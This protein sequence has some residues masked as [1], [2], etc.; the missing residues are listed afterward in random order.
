M[1]KKFLILC[2]G[3]SL[4]V[5]NALAVPANP[6]PVN[7]TQPDGS[8]VTLT[9]HGDEFYH[10]TTT[11]DGY[12]VIQ[13]A[14]GAYTYLVP[15]NSSLSR[16]VIAHNPSQRSQVEINYLNMLGK[17][18]PDNAS[19]VQ[20]AMRASRD[21][22]EVCLPMNAANYDYHNFKGLVLLV[23]YSDCSFSMNDPWR[24]FEDMVNQRDYSG[25][26]P[27][28]GGFKQEYTGSVVD[29]FYDNSFGQFEP[30]FDVVGPVKVSK[31]QYF[32]EGTNNI[33]ELIAE[34]CNVA[35]PDVDFSEYDRDGDGTVD[36]FYVIFAGAGSHVSGND[37]RLLWPHAWS[38]GGNIY[39]GVKLGRYACSTE[40]YGPPAWQMCDGIG[41]I[42]HEF[43]HVLGLMDEYDTDYDGSGGLSDHPNNWSVMA[44]GNYLNYGRTPTGYSLMQRYQ[45]GFCVPVEITQEGSYTLEDIDVINNGYRISTSNPAEYFLLENKRR[46]GSKWNEYNNG[47]GMLVYRV[48]STNT[49]AW[50]SNSINADP[51][52]CYYLLL[53]AER[54]RSASG[55]ID[56]DG[57]P[58]PGS[59]NKTAI[60]YDTEPALTAWSGRG[61]NFVITDITENSDGTISFVASK[62]ELIENAEDFE[63]IFT[64]GKYDRDLPGVYTNWIFYNA[65]TEEPEKG[66][67]GRAA[68]IYKNGYIESGII[69]GHTMTLS[70]DVYNP[71]PRPI[72]FNV[73]YNTGGNN[74]DYL[75]EPGGMAGISLK[76][77]ETASYRFDIPS[78]WRDDLKIQIRLANNSGD[79]SSAV[80]FDN[81]AVIQDGTTEV[82][83]IF[84]NETL[85]YRLE[86]GKLLL[87][88]L[89]GSVYKVFDITGKCLITVPAQEE[90]L[91]SLPGRGCYIV[92]DGKNTMKILY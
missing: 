5:F 85:N 4:G 50:S 32:V 62:Q 48:D 76:T 16:G 44:A 86:D 2:A 57:D 41:V 28:H 40:L 63:N 45:S 54:K 84:S 46:I 19:P 23:E 26:T 61:A 27:D 3:L 67:K 39:D 11:E 22:G 7:V 91:I 60:T 51:S 6:M 17:V 35:D 20:K 53:R 66:W 56:H 34:A 92:T 10:F 88:G 49:A 37:S 30:A 80:Y 81:I 47:E 38:M 21:A 24:R 12:T 73:R 1:T 78:D 68:G 36:M 9:L 79:N 8:E 75:Y 33:R 58:F 90:T 25:F 69:E 59:Y 89:S 71:S 77:D 55:I 74:W 29:Y 42:C 13:N 82:K 15:D 43:S 14:E 65:V 64:E 18:R 72:T 52:H 70:M 83:N 87:Q 31:S